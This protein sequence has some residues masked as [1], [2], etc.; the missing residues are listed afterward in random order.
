MIKEKENY[1]K[2]VSTVREIVVREQLYRMFPKIPKIDI[3]FCSYMFIKLVDGF[4]S[5]P[6]Y[7]GGKC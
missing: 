6:L 5:S 3:I 4:K 2:S 7:E 1:K